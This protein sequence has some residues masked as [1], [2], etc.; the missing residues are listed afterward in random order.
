MVNAKFATP[1]THPRKTTLAQVA[2]ILQRFA[3]IDAR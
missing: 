1:K 2:N 3:M